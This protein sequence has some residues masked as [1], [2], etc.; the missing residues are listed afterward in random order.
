MNSRYA[1]GL[2]VMLAAASCAVPS[3]ATGPSS[4]GMDGSSP[5]LDLARGSRTPPG[6]ASVTLQVNGL[7]T[8][9]TSQSLS[10]AGA[11]LL[12]AV[13]DSQHHTLT[14]GN[15]NPAIY[16]ATVSS[17]AATLVLPPLPPTATTVNPAAPSANADIFSTFLLRSNFPVSTPPQYTDLE[18][19]G[20]D[21]THP[22]TA[23][24]SGDAVV[25]NHLDYD[26]SDGPD[27]IPS[28]P[29][30]LMGSGEAAADVAAGFPMVVPLVNWFLVGAKLDESSPPAGFNSADESAVYVSGF[31]LTSGGTLH[32][33]Y[34]GF[35][36][37]QLTSFSGEVARLV[38]NFAAT[39][40]PI[41]K[42]TAQTFDNTDP[43]APPVTLGTA[44]TPLVALT[45]AQ[46]DATTQGMAAYTDL[47]VSSVTSPTNL[48]LTFTGMPSGATLLML[49][50]NVYGALSDNMV[51]SSAFQ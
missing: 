49:D 48:D 22:W 24:A 46:S 30:F 42:L 12:V 9:R 1:I 29:Q 13:T 21:S 34:P 6:W 4:S 10:S 11:T 5:I 47:D 15:G 41:V 7:D 2:V 18:N 31:S 20:T 14:D 25:W 39:N 40:G 19:Y 28:H 23:Y 3:P 36:N 27:A 16:K 26:M 44:S 35:V 37:T 8:G 38:V 17:G 43:S 45:L 50:K 32:L 51:G 33:R